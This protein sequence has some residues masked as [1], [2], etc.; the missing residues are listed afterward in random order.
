M[1][2]C[3]STSYVFEGMRG[4]L[5]QAEFKWDLFVG[6]VAL[7][8]VCVVVGVGVFFAGFRGALLQ[9]GE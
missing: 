5:L 4:A 3:P 8:A 7:N 1:A 6:A 2:R 9:M